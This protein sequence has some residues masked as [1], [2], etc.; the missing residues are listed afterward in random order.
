MKSHCDRLAT[1][2][3]YLVVWVV[4]VGNKRLSSMWCLR[5]CKGGQQERT[6]SM[7]VTLIP[8]LM[9]QLEAGPI[10]LATKR[11]TS[12]VRQAVERPGNPGRKLPKREVRCRSP[13]ESVFSSPRAVAFMRAMLADA[14]RGAT[15]TGL[16]GQHGA[17][18]D[19][20]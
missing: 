15:H 5:V 20:I 12:A 19:E 4:S 2:L 17:R 14:D 1:G 10:V 18:S 16:S 7:L 3:L 11:P 13:D 9:L 6:P 8:I